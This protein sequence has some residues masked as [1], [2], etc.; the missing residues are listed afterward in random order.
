MT[1]NSSVKSF[2][3][4]KFLF[5]GKRCVIFIIKHKNASRILESLKFKRL[6][7]RNRD[8][9][10]NRSFNCKRIKHQRNPFHRLSPTIFV[11]SFH[12]VCSSTL[13]VFFSEVF[14]YSAV[15]SCTPNH[16]LSIVASSSNSKAEIRSSRF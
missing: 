13:C 10:E 2:F 16:S 9:P 15:G 4:F 5:V 6:C 1:N 14:Q 7:P 3:F 8:F 12:T 11:L